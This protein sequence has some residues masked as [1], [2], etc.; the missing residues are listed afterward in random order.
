MITIKGTVSEIGN[1]G[2]LD[3][4]CGVRLESCGK[5]IAITGLTVADCKLI[6]THYGKILEIKITPQMGD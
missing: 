3:N 6:G 1:I 2:S 4:G 5:E